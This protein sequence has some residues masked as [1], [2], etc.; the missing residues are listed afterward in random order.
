[1]GC[2]TVYLDKC[3][4]LPIMKGS[5]GGNCNA[6]VTTTVKMVNRYIGQKDM[7]Q[8]KSDTGHAGS[9]PEYNEKYEFV[10]NGLD[11]HQLYMSV[12][13]DKGKILK[14][15]FMGKIQMNLY[16]IAGLDDS[17]DTPIAVT[18]KLVDVDQGEI[19]IRLS[20]KV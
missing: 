14:D 19:H 8:K 15:E 20:Y 12:K 3:T 17:E 2:L 13:C 11:D 4:G 6:Y 5:F 16:E 9:D 1:M 18:Q 10:I 7:G